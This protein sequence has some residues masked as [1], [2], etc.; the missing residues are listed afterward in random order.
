MIDA[1]RSQSSRF[2]AVTVP[3]FRQFQT[4]MTYLYLSIDSVNHTKRLTFSGDFDAIG[5]GLAAL[6]LSLPLRMHCED[7]RCR[8]HE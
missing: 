6:G 1:N 2:R 5:N 7:I 3:A 4:L 8:R